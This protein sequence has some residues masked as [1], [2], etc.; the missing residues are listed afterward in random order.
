MGGDA[1]TVVRDRIW[2]FTTKSSVVRAGMILSSPE[3][4]LQ[5]GCRWLERPQALA[6]AGVRR[7]RTIG[8][9]II[10]RITQ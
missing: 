2:R 6:D 8:Q 4:E 1:N 10:S 3:M 9:R 5:S 7:A